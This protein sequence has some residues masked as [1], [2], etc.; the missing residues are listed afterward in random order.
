MTLQDFLIKRSL[1][2]DT[3]PKYRNLCA[4]CLQPEFGCYCS[5]VKAFDPQV[6][7]VILMHPIEAK[8]RIATGRMAHLCLKNS[9]LIVGQDYSLDQRVNALMNNPEYFPMVLYP[10]KSALNLNSRSTENTRA[11]WPENKKLMLFVID[12]TW[13]TARKTMHLSQNIKRLPRISFSPEKP[14]QF[15]VR[16]QPAA[17]CYS[18]IEA[19]HFVLDCL[20]PSLAMDPSVRAHD[21]LLLVFQAM[22]GRQLEF[23]EDFRRH[24]RP[25]SYRK[26]FSLK[27]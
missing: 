4:K 7:I 16:K 20:T 8:R 11:I 9:E 15:K 13:A 17:H 18:T 26:P 12:G 10:G 21:H 3:L 14:S 27:P 19:I 23:I 22:V 5:L 1:W 2:Q 6:K 25:G 24:P